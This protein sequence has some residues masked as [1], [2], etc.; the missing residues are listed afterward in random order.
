MNSRVGR[1]ETVFQVQV[2]HDHVSRW[3]KLLWSLK[4][5]RRR[6]IFD[7]DMYLGIIQTTVSVSS[8][9]TNFKFAKNKAVNVPLSF[10]S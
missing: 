6:R 9:S 3:T 7:Q 5:F 8:E 1:R 2:P 10:S 4:H